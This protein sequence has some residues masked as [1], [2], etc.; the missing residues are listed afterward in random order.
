MSL[1]KITYAGVH[2]ESHSY[3]YIFSIFLSDSHNAWTLPHI[4]NLGLRQ[5]TTYING[6]ADFKPLFIAVYWLCV[7]GNL[8]FYLYS[9]RE[10]G[11]G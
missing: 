9:E 10:N 5:H 8:T 1:L 3:V 2:M 11:Y 4:W 7:L 6:V